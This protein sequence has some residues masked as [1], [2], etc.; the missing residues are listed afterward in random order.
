MAPLRTLLSSRAVIAGLVALGCLTLLISTLDNKPD[1][2]SR[3]NSGNSNVD[4][5][6][7]IQFEKSTIQ[8]D[9]ALR[10]IKD[11]Q[12]LSEYPHRRPRTVQHLLEKA[13]GYYD[14]V[15]KQRHELLI[16]QGFGTA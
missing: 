12:P 6:S 10:P 16:Q 8:W 3:W 7:K 11:A 14:R 4:A 15:V 5:G 2:G 13:H 1:L 9:D